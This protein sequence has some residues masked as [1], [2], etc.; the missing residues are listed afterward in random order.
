MVKLGFC[1]PACCGGSWTLTVT[2]F[3]GPSGGIFDITRI[4]VDIWVPIFSN[5]TIVTNFSSF[6]E[7]Y[8]GFE[9]KF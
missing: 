4:W 9:F 8:V 2:A 6:G 7:G 5:L 3:F 1:G